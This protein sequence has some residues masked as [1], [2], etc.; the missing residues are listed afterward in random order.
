[1]EN[2]KYVSVGL[3]ENC[4]QKI[5]ELAQE[6]SCSIPGYIRQLVQVHLRELEQKKHT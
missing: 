1:M 5:K 6:N 4:Y 2:K 3:T